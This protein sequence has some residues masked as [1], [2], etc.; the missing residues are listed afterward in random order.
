VNLSDLIA[1]LETADPNQ[2]VKHGF[3]NPHSYRGDYMDLAFEPAEN[4][5]VREML[6]AARSALAAT[7]QGWKGGDFVMHGDTWCWLSAEGDVSGE[8]ISALLLDLILATPAVTPPATD[9]TALRDRIAD[10][11][12]D[13]MARECTICG[14]DY[15]A[16]DAVL[17]VL[18]TT[19]NPA[20][21]L[22]PAERTMLT[23]ALDQAQERIWSEDG[24]TDDDQTAVDS[25]RRLADETQPPSSGSTTSRAQDQPT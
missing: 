14:S 19:T 11:I 16:A 18:P 1:R 25:L 7:F 9:Q 15:D 4:V 21:V 17:A 2:T 12:G 24:F 6:D 13:F 5:T 3:H 8:T 22:S 10:A 23:Y 20:A